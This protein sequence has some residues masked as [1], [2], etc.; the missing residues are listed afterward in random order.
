M[1]FMVLVKANKS[2]E[3]GMLPDEK[4]IVAMG[5]FN[6]SLAKAGVLLSGEGLAAS[7]KGA[8]ISFEGGKPIVRH[9]PFADAR[10]LIAGFWMVRAGSK[11]EA[12]ERF[13]RC[14]PEVGE[15]EIRQV[16][17]S[18]D[19]APAIKTAEGRATMDAERALREREPR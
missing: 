6:E 2:S 16:Y 4:S 9:G 18:E 15:I 7:S 3:A 12:I 13:S 17:E 14:P 5:K 8:R 19:F 1:R 10:G 11:E